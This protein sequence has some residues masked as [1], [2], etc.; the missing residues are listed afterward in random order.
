[1]ILPCVV[2]GDQ[3]VPNQSSSGGITSYREEAAAAA[4]VVL[5]TEGH[6]D[7]IAGKHLTS[8]FE[9][10]L[11]KKHAYEKPRSFAGHATS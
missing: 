6:R 7:S 2:D 9:M 4:A 3:H 5:A 1:L 8:K 10:K 11:S